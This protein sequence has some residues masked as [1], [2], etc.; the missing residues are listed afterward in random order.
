MAAVYVDV[1][2]RR[3]PERSRLGDNVDAAPATAK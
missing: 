1:K 2:D 3:R